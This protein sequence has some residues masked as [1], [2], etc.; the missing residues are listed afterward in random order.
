MIRFLT[1]IL[2]FVSVGCEQQTQSKEIL[3]VCTHGAARS[4]IAAAYFNKLA[5]ENELNYHAVYR[6]TEPDDDLTTETK[7]GLLQANFDIAGWKPKKVSKK[8]VEQAYRII[9]FD[10]DLPIQNLESGKIERWDG[11]PS[12]SKNYTVARDEILKRVH[13][14]IDSL[15]KH[16]E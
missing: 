10:L 9:N 6:G 3:F 12:I 5:K 2:A 4:P 13:M 1:I 8:D 11:T 16:Q 14:L 15:S 7:S